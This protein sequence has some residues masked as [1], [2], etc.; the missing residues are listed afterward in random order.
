[1]YET[2][3]PG[4]LNLRRA[5]RDVNL[6][7]G[8][9]IYPLGIFYISVGLGS[10]QV[11]INVALDSGS[12]TLL[13]P[14][15]GCD[16]CTSDIVYD[17]SASHTSKPIPCPSFH[18]DC[19]HCSNGDQCAFSNTYQTCNL[20][21]PSQPCTV[22]G[23]MY[24][25]QF[26]LG[27]LS[28]KVAI[29]TIEFQTKNFEQFYVI[30]GVIG[31]ACKTSFGLPIP[32]QALVNA[33]KVK[34]MFSV[35]LDEDLVGGILTLG[36]ADPSLYTGS[37]SY[38]PLVYAGGLYA[39]NLQNIGIG[40]HSTGVQLPQLIVDS[41]TNILLL[42]ANAFNAMQKIFLTH[43]ASLAHVSG[44]WNGKCFPLTAAEIAAYP[45]LS[46]TFPSGSGG[47]FQLTMVPST[48]LMI[49]KAGSGLHCLSIDNTGPGGLP[50]IGDTTMQNYVTLFDRENSQLGFAPVNKQNCKYTPSPT[51]SMIEVN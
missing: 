9:N 40:P 7:V 26:N 19:Y 39:I 24:E 4:E 6:P 22:T 14:G 37:F 34:D 46:L 21:D 2:V 35:C 8:G 50:I 18:Y 15:K 13:V 48:Y 16:G 29:G 20:T 31:F 36:G 27:G 5:R 33:G 44:L 17:P 11:D 51:P 28:D 12:C 41:G 45:T 1:M 43:Y 42:P 47:T 30:D 32:L 25:D 10:P 3:Y 49:K 38:T 23:V